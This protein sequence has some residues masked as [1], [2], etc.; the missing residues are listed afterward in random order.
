M[1]GALTLVWEA[2]SM[3]TPSRVAVFID[4]QNCYK[5]AR[6][7]FCPDSPSHVDGQILPR[8]LALTLKNK[9]AG[10]RE[11]I[12]VWVYRGLPSSKFD[13]KGYGAADRQV[14]MWSQ[15]ALVHPVTRPLNYRD[16]EAPKEKGID[17]R[18]AIDIVTMA[19]RDECDI[20][21]LMSDDTDLLPALEAVAGM[22]STSAIEVA[23]WQPSRDEAATPLRV[24][25]HACLIH[26]L[27][28]ADYHRVQ[29]YS[30]LCNSRPPFMILDESSPPFR[31]LRLDL[32]WRGS[33]FSARW[34]QRPNPDLVHAG[35]DVRGWRGS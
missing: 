18:I 29:H 1:T 9:A 28:E 23:T 8:L 21:V 3:S 35:R 15:Q 12:G 33:P 26:R 24:P 5:G 30:Q 2:P 22:K 19:M 34:S 6:W 13:S 10:D 11:L 31:T 27:T 14:A 16:P 17:V 32:E 4:Y 20:A 25:G 7:A